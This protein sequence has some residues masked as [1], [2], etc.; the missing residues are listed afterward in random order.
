MKQLVYVSECTRA[1]T[2]GEI[3]ELLKESREG[4]LQHQ[5]TGVLFLVYNK[6]LQCLEGEPEAVDQLI[7]NIG[8]DERNKNLVVLSSE[9]IEARQFPEW[10]M[11]FRVFSIEEFSH[12]EGFFDLDDEEK[13]GQIAERS[14]DVIKLMRA[15]YQSA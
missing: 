6:F 5:I 14:A 2:P 10:S 11:G 13:L 8:A 1:L 12:E 4:N 3:K 9:T 7:E 15:I